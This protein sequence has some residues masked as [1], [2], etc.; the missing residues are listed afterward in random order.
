[1]ADQERWTVLYDGDCGLCKWMLAGLL[2]RDRGRRMAPVALQ[3]PEAEQLL[4]DLTP[5]ERM[6][7]VH[8]VSPSG[9]R[10]SGGAAL[11]AILR[12]LPEGSPAAAGLGRF[13]AVTDRAYRW[14]ADH[15][16]LLSRAI[17][18]AA[19]QRAGAYVSRREEAQAPKTSAPNAFSPS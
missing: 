19:K 5:E 8:V 14:V 6:A 10:F 9:Q 11:P 3:R 1:V 16:S 12:L 17:P 2:V 15:R 18:A 7:S 13:P 4:A